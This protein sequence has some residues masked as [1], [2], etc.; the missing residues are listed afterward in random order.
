M[1]P[2]DLKLR[3]FGFYDKPV[4]VMVVAT[5]FV[6]AVCVTLISLDGWRTWQARA[7]QMHESEIVASNLARSLSQ[8]AE[9]VITNADTT[10]MS[11]VDR[12][13]V[14][15]TGPAERLRLYSLL[16][17]E[18]GDSPWLHGL[19]VYDEQGKWIVNS[20]AQRVQQLN[21]SDREYFIYHR[22]HEDRGPF[23]GVPVRSRSTG[24]W[25]LTV[26]RRI[27]HPD[28]SFAGVALASISMDYFQKF[29]SSF[30]IGNKG[31]IELMLDNGTLLV[32]RPFI[33]S[34][35]GTN[36]AFGPLFTKYLRKS[37]IG[38][39]IIKSPI[40]DVVR[41]NGYQHVVHYPL[42]VNVALSEE[43]ILG[44]WKTEAYFHTFGVGLLAIVLGMLGYRMI[45][46]IRLRL[47][48]ETRLSESET[49]LRTI[50]DNMPAFISYI[51]R[52]QR[53]RFCNA[54]YLAEFNLTMGELLGKS[55]RDL[56]GPEA[57][58][59]IE[60]YVLK[61]LAGQK[62]VFE[63]QALERGPGCYS[64]Y[65]YVPDEDHNGAVRGFYAMVLDITPRKTAELKLTA[66]EKLLR[67]LT[68]H[69][70]ALV[71][72]IDRAEYF[73]FNNQPYEKWLGKPLSEITGHHVREA[74]GDEAYFKYKR[75]FDQALAGKKTD[76]AFASERDGVKRYFSSAYIPQFDEDGEVIGVCSMIN[77]IT[78]LKKVE[79]QLIKLARIDALTG[80][81][82]RVQFDETLRKAIARSHR[83]GLALALMYLDI[84]HFK[85]INDT[86]GHQAGDEALCEFS[87]RLS[88]S[89]RKT[90]QVA[91]LS[92]DEFVIII[93]EM[94]SVDEVEI[95]ARKV[96]Q[97]MEVE[98]ILGGT[99][100]QVT[101]SIGIAILREGDAEPQSLLRRADQAL[102]RAKKGGRNTYR[103]DE[104]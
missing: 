36:L 38:T 80:L 3:Y 11:L 69:L 98:F 76:F 94:K 37:S 16:S 70:P 6:V 14:E 17:T 87:R 57:Y 41:L 48:A 39:A 84:D 101:T 65:H 7:I 51:D 31:A 90:D 75:F 86:Y 59:T 44:K 5:V 99:P 63:R 64:L 25:I 40:D 68:D 54:Q 23:I 61:A 33:E 28:G 93:E 47:D 42:V 82:N 62:I 32:R 85:T 46:I 24:E 103:A 19:F 18:V 20:Q 89:V 1:K 21:N 55:M 100:Y 95:V 66:K 12:V 50:T 8:H 30:D 53:Y 77:D 73:Q 74:C 27:N 52:D 91:R 49:R 26:S 15:G 56:F 13:E 2:H 22:S 71:S 97:A 83:S 4:S 81:P 78:D 60:P 43:E 45:G 10:L 102:Y 35:I 104:D 96:I 79:L 92:G 29:Y 72:Y 9:D 88:A 58:A 67:G 34:N